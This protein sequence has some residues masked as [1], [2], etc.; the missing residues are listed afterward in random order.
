[1]MTPADYEPNCV[2]LTSLNPKSAARS[3]RRAWRRPLAVDTSLEGDLER[4]S[5]SMLMEFKS[6]RIGANSLPSAVEI[7]PLMGISWVK[8]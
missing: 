5:V 1:M 7:G 3:T 8:H 6:D 2:R 4:A